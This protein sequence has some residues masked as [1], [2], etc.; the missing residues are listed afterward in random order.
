MVGVLFPPYTKSESPDSSF[1]VNEGRYRDVIARMPAAVWTADIR[2]EILFANEQTEQMTG[3]TPA[4]FVAGGAT[5]WARHVHPADIGSLFDKWNELFLR[6]E[7]SLDSEYRFLR[8]DDRWIWLHQRLSLVSEQDREP[9]IIGISV[10]ITARHAAEE[11]QRSSELRYRML[12]EQVRDVIFAIDSAGRFQSL[13]PAFEAMTGWASHEWIGKTFVELMDPSSHQLARDRFAEVLSG[14]HPGYD[15]YLLHTKWGHTITIEASSEGVRIDGK[16][17][18]IVGIARDITKRKHADAEA[19][20]ESRLASVGQLATS[21]AHEFNNVLMS[22]MPFAEVVQRRFPNDDGV[23]TAT[24]HII[25]AVKR[26]REISQQVLRFSRPVKPTLEAI[27]VADWLREF[28]GRDETTVG[29]QHRLVRRLP[30]EDGDLVICADPMLLD[31]VVT[32]L[33]AN[34]RDAMPRGGTITISA[35]RS[36]EPNTIDIVVE[37]AG[38]GIADSALNHIFEP[39][40]TTKH[41]GTGLGLTVA[42]QAMKQQE[43]TIAVQSV[44]GAGTTFTLSFRES[45]PPAPVVPAVMKA[46]GRLLIVEDD[47]AVGEGLR[48]LLDDAG[49]QVHLVTRGLEAAPA[50]RFFKPDLVL[51]DVNLPDVDGTE[52]YDR[53][54]SDWADLPVIFSTGHA[55]S[56]ALEQLRHRGVPSIMK[57]YDVDELLAVI[58]NLPSNQRGAL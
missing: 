27:R 44:V 10:D 53:I 21:V 11:A 1:P 29:P 5:L 12:V 40:F 38:S 58:S 42:H 2:G 54:R 18:G 13:N 24:G 43:G 22:I 55:D 17:V 45:A 15:E 46:R 7:G 51:L 30:A 35:K 9:Y 28:G 23:K 6:R 36:R 50:V 16:M 20:R 52:V 47:E 57:P 32:N 31:Q 19:A 33:I 26:G 14:G 39:L 49:F 41:G 34:A 25:D 4:E 48:T 8:K 3:F 56:T 37:D